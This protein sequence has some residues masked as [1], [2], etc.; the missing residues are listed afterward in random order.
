MTGLAFKVRIPKIFR[1]GADALFNGVHPS[2]VIVPHA[3]GI[4]DYV[5]HHGEHN[6]PVVSGVHHLQGIAKL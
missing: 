1:K 3:T 2:S 5:S 6:D 4:D